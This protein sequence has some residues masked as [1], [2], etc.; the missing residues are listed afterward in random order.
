MTSI[1]LLT[2]VGLALGVVAT[3][4][5]AQVGTE[6]DRGVPPAGGV[7]PSDRRP[8]L[9]IEEAMA[10]ALAR[11]SL[12]Q[13]L[14]VLARIAGLCGLLV[15]Y[16]TIEAE[17]LRELFSEHMNMRLYRASF[18]TTWMAGYEETRRLDLANAVAA[19][20]MIFSYGSWEIVVA[21]VM[22][23]CE[24]ESAGERALVLIPAIV[25]M[26]M[27]TILFGVGVYVN[28]SLKSPIP[29]ILLALAYDAMLVLF[30]YFVIKISRRKP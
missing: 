9:T 5:D 3:S 7:P 13:A 14:G 11:F 18:L 27:D 23:Y 16:Q 17:G 15:V 30:A 4:H 20:L 24:G 2:A 28:G 29:A 26:V 8:R 1:Y 25:L 21:R 19:A 12:R 22:K 10:N 6:T